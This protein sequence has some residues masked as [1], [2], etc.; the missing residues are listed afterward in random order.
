MGNLT[1]AAAVVVADWK[2]GTDERT[3]FG[4]EKYANVPDIAHS[5]PLW[6]E[7][8]SSG[9]PAFRS[10]GWKQT[11]R[12]SLLQRLQRIGQRGPLWFTEQKVN[13]LWHDDIP[14]NLKP[15]TTPHALQGGLEDSSAG[16][17]GKQPV[18]MV[19]AERDEMTLPAVVKTRESPWHD[20]NLVFARWSSL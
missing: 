2:P 20:G 11:P 16:V 15:E 9:E 4:E 3:G 10:L 6:L 8:G 14:I 17:S 5:S 19:A 1:H 13:M 18:A 7:W 12:Y